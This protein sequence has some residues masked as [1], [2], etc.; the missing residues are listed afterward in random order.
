MGSAQEAVLYGGPTSERRSGT[1]AV[2]PSRPVPPERVP[3]VVEALRTIVPLEGLTDEE[4]TWLATHGKEQFAASGALIFRGGA[5]ADQLNFI[6]KGEVH[7]R[8]TQSGPLALFIGRSGQMTGKLPFS[9]MKAY[10]GDSSAVGEVWGLN[11]HESLFPAMLEA[12]PSMA[13]RSVNVLLDRVREVT[14]M[15][16]QAEKLSALGKLAAN[17]AHELNNPASAAQR[18]AATMLNELRQYGDHRYELGAL[19]IGPE[20]SQRLRAWV[21]KTRTRIKLYQAALSSNASSLELADRE[22]A[23][24]KWLAAHDVA[25]AWNIAPTLAENGVPIDD[26]EDFAAEFPDRVIA[27]AFRSF[28]SALRVMRITETI[29]ASTDRIF[30]QLRPTAYAD[31]RLWLRAEPG[32]DRVA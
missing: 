6:L 16:Q 2:T 32:V 8:R 11:I 17:L 3:L 14:R 1:R 12:I 7:V 26:L 4:Y 29:E 10:G 5:P 18:S 31:Q 25:D 22:D 13:Q 19:C 21:D 28:A 20:Y 23:I 24:Y 27:P 9:R 30:D 15:E